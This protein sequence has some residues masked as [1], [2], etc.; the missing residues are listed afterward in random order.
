MHT[1]P[2]VFCIKF[3]STGMSSVVRSSD[4]VPGNYRPFASRLDQR[5]AR[6]HRNLPDHPILRRVRLVAILPALPAKGT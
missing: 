2:G 6:C 4:I 3:H 1:L 5:E